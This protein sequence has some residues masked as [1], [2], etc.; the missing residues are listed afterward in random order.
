MLAEMVALHIR[1]Q[2]LE[3]RIAQETTFPLQAGNDDS[4][5]VRTAFDSEP[6]RVEIEMNQPSNVQETKDMVEHLEGVSMSQ[7]SFE[8]STTNHVTFKIGQIRTIP[9]KLTYTTQL[10]RL[11]PCIWLPLKEEATILLDIYITELNYIQHVTHTPSL[12][13]VLNETYRPIESG[14][15]VHPSKVVLLLSIIAHTTHVWSMPDGLNRERPLFLSST[16]ARSQTSTWIKATYTVLETLQEGPSLALEA[17]QGIII[18]SYVLCNIEGV[19]LRYRSLISTGLLLCREMGLHRIDHVFNADAAQTLKAEVGRRVW[20]YLTATDWYVSPREFGTWKLQSRL[21]TSP[22]LLAARYGGPSGGIYQTNPLHFHVNKPLNINDIDLLATG[23]QPSLP[24][25][26]QTDMSYF[27]QRIRLAEISRTLVDQVTSDPFQRSAHLMTMDHQLVQLTHET[28][29]FFLLDYYDNIFSSEKPNHVFIQAYFLNTLIHTQRC[30]L[31]LTTLTRPSASTGT[32]TTPSSRT[33]CLYS[34]R[35][36]I[37]LET[38]LLQSRHPFARRPQRPPAGLYS[39]FIATIALL[40]DACVNRSGEVHAELQEDRD[41]AKGLRMIADARDD[42][43]AAAKLYESLMQ[44]LEKYRDAGDTGEKYGS[45]V[46]G[47]SAV[48]S[49]QDLPPDRFGEQQ[50]SSHVNDAIQLDLVDWDDLFSSVS[51]SPFF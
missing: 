37:Y 45:S 22:R 13:A 42:S 12:P 24:L 32:S 34:A 33:A 15:P 46:G 20:W 18:L 4:E 31:H 38:K 23:P 47:Q 14:E 49:L 27:L 5:G 40:M 35:Q 41:L 19:S 26:H 11:T 2:E 44:I 21:T 6:V 50:H 17:I 7:S 30:K 51:S 10:G 8:L 39:I 9:P 3:E 43:L 1:V 36:L 16:Q 28:P 48:E 29:A 25:S